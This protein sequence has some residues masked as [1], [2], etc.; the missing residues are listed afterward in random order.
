[1]RYLV[2]LCFPLFLFANTFSYKL[3]Y[4]EDK[5]SLKIEEIKEQD[6]RIIQDDYINKGFNFNTFWI[7]LKVRNNSERPIKKIF[8]IDNPTLDFLEFYEDEKLK[9]ITGDHA[10]NINRDIRDIYFAFNLKIDPNEEKV[11]YIKIQTTNAFVLKFY[12]DSVDEY[13]KK[14]DIKKMFLLFYFGFIASIIIYNIFLLFALKERSYLFYILFQFV[15]LFLLLSSSGLGYYLLWQDSYELNEFVL[16][17]FDDF[18]ILLGVLFTQSF[19]NVKRNFPKINRVINYTIL[20]ILYVMLT[21][22]EYHYL[23]VKPVMIG[24]ILLI[25]V[26]AIFA[27]YK[28]VPSAKLFLIGWMLLILGAIAT[29]LK[30]FG[31][32]ETNFLTTWAIYVGSMFE[33]IIFSI[34][35]A[36]RIE[37]LKQDKER[38][39]HISKESLNREVYRKTKH[40]DEALKQKEVLLKEIH[41]RVKNNLQII[42]SFVTISSLKEKSR[43][44]KDRYEALN[45]RIQAISL[46]HDF[47]YEQ[48]NIDKIDTKKYITNIVNNLNIAYNTKNKKIE[49]DYNIIPCEIEFEKLVLVALIINELV[50]NSFKYAF[51]KEEYPKIKISFFRRVNYYY[52]V[53]RDNGIGFEY[54]L[55]K[56]DSMG[57]KIVHRLAQKQLNAKVVFKN[58][59]KK[60]TFG[61]IFE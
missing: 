50:T 47:F 4:F 38:L 56:L 35:L 9:I 53:T 19:L 55:N 60:T 30:N 8:H 42:S 10:K 33:A 41:H 48:E 7:R 20:I 11:Y 40:L 43:D 25:F 14:S 54:D 15:T 16:K 23:L 36:K 17:I 57:L 21:P 26:V 46:L 3:S 28:K 24:A 58:K 2:L 27:I 37:T 59:N 1:M 5:N 32:L 49:F 51:R 22:W 6:F 31:V 18:A 45:Q 34:A 61:F 44:S 13:L 39:L 29:L 12:V 52:L